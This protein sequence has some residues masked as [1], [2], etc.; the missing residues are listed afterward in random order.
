MTDGEIWLTSDE[1]AA[2]LKVPQKTLA[3]WASNRNGPPFAKIGRYRRYR[4]S[5]LEAWEQS[6]LDEYDEP[7]RPVS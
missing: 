3:V 4:L 1:V 7:G 2:R 5:D 6:R